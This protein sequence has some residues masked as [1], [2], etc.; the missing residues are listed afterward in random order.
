M[1]LRTPLIIVCLVF[2][3]T[4]A[5]AQRLED[6]DHIPLDNK[7]IRYSEVPDTDPVARLQE[8]LNK[9]EVSLAYQPGDL[10]YLPA[11]LKLLLTKG[12]RGVLSVMLDILAL[13][14]QCSVFFLLTMYSGRN[15]APAFDF[16]TM[17]QV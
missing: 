5:V 12:G 11:L 16:V 10:G 8:R 3:T 1:T 14:A 6:T 2:A 13:A 15:G 9:G 17:L 7:A 4:W